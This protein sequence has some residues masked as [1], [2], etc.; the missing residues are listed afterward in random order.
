MRGRL[1]LALAIVVIVSAVPR[2][3]PAAAEP[4][5][6]THFGNCHHAEVTPGSGSFDTEIVV[7]DG[8]GGAKP[9]AGTDSC[10]GC[11]YYLTPA[12]SANGVAVDIDG[13]PVGN[14]GLCGSA[15]FSCP[16]S[17]IRFKVYVRQ[18]PATTFREVSTI[19][20]GPR[21]PVVTRD[22]LIAS[23]QSLF[24]QLPLTS[25]AVNWQPTSGAVTGV[26]AIFYATG[27]AP[28]SNETT[29]GEITVS[30]TAR[31]TSWVWHVAPGVDVASSTA[32]APYPD[33]AAEHLYTRVGSYPVSVTTTWTGYATVNGVMS[34]EPV[35]TVSVTSPMRQLRVREGRTQLVDG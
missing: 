11:E 26:P 18:P 28:T 1:Q 10:P 29:L 14:D 2:L 13:N 19:C 5:P 7:T 15:A 16:G 35:G 32:G 24:R 27:S 20:I 12:C 22:Q 30:V 34:D 31:A 25:S 17:E 21:N 9:V 33:H 8:R 4:A 3:R 6:C 23:A